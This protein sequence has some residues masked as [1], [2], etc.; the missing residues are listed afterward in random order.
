VR[1]HSNCQTI[2][3][4][5]Y[6][7]PLVMIEIMG[8]KMCIINSAKVATDLLDKRS[9]IYSDRP[10]MPM[11]NDLY[12]RTLTGEYYTNRNCLEWAGISTWDCSHIRRPIKR[13]AKY[14]ISASMHKHL[15][16]TFPYRRYSTILIARLHADRF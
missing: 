14:S 11:V 7:G 10:A 5:P 3:A 16:C 2:T 13:V 9:A 6:A 12:V 4:E 8:Q 15:T 1:I